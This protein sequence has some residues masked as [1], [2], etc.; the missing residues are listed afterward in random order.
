MNMLA[1]AGKP[2]SQL[3]GANNDLLASGIVE[4]QGERRGT[5]YRISESD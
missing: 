4:R 1:Y 5:L 2:E 3:N